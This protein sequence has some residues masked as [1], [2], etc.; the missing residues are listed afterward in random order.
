MRHR[1]YYKRASE[2][3]PKLL[4]ECRKAQLT[5]SKAGGR[6]AKVIKMALLDGSYV[7]RRYR[8]MC[9][10]YIRGGKRCLTVTKVV[11][12]YITGDKGGPPE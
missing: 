5:Y 8:K 6:C 9:H 12:V 11:Q 4:Q 1:Y 3:A 2:G 10:S 7:S